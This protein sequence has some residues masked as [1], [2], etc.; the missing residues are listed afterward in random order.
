MPIDRKA[1]VLPQFRPYRQE[2]CVVRRVFLGLDPN[3]L[4]HGPSTF[5]WR[6]EGPPILEPDRRTAAPPFGPFPLKSHRDDGE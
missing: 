3:L 4:H 5:G 1:V 6:A 2:N